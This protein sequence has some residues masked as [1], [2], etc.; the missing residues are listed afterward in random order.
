MGR[1]HGVQEIKGFYSH[2][3]GDMYSSR[4]LNIR[5]ISIQVYSD[6]AWAEFSWNF[7]ATRRHEGSSVSFHGMETQIYRKN[8]EGWCLVHVYYSARLPSR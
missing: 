3:M 2:E 5:D 4:S 1:W 8:H 6:A 7:S